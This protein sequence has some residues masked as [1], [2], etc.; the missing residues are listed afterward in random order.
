M[1]SNYLINSKETVW[2]NEQEYRMHIL[3]DRA[4]APVI[5]C[6]H[7]G[8]GLPNFAYIKRYQAPLAENATLVM[9]DQR[10]AGEAFSASFAFKKNLM[11]ER[12]LADIHNLAE[13]LKQRFHTDKIILFGHSF[14]A[15]LS[16]WYA[17]AHP[18]NVAFILNAGQPVTLHAERTLSKEQKTEYAIRSLQ[19]ALPVLPSFVRDY[20]VS[21]LLKYALGVKWSGNTPLA[22]GEPDL[23]NTVKTL[24]VPVYIV[25]GTADVI[26]PYDEAKAWFDALEAPLKHLYVF[27]DV[28]H[29]PMWEQAEKFNE[30]AASL[31]SDM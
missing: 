12:I 25:M 10:G 27:Q 13:Y 8:P 16:V 18:E 26:T 14:G 24:S 28:G 29:Q 9:W 5:L 19:T 7:G 2:T 23:M 4:D 11:K 22:K 3:S 21:G 30:I 17:Q 31:L 6:L 1:K 20:K 15:V